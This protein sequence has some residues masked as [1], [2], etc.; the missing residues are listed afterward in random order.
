[1]CRDLTDAFSKRANLTGAWDHL[2][3]VILSETDLSYHLAGVNLSG[4][5]LNQCVLSAR[6]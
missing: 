4:A 6:N 5:S 3:T 2:P 1:M